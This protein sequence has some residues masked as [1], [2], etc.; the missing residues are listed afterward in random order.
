[1]GVKVP[2]P[3]RRA[4]RSRTPRLG[5][6]RADHAPADEAAAVRTHR[7]RRAEPARGGRRAAARFAGRGPGCVRA[8]RVR[9]PPFSPSRAAYP[10]L[11]GAGGTRLRGRKT[12]REEAA[13]TPSPA[14][15]ALGGRPQIG[16]WGRRGLRKLPL[17]ASPSPHPRVP[18]LHVCFWI[19][20]RTEQESWQSL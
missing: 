9:S 18:T 20:H 17:S 11:T 4:L 15:G 8:G 16:Q 2:P 5:P 14:I 10:H 1:M 13:V 3:R 6:G 7:A 19:G 12:R